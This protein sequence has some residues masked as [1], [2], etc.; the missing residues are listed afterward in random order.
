MAA[1]QFHSVFRDVPPARDG[2]Y[3]LGQ[4]FPFSREH[5]LRHLPDAA[6][7]PRALDLCPVVGRW[8]VIDRRTAFA[9]AQRAEDDL[10]AVHALVAAYVW[11]AG[12][13]A[14]T[15]ARLR[16]IFDANPSGIGESLLTALRAA[17]TEGAVA[18][19]TLL[20][21]KGEHALSGL[22]AS[23]FTKVLYFGAFGHSAG[24]HQPLILDRDVT[25]AVNALR[26]S[27]WSPGG[28]WSPEQYEDYLGYVAG[29]AE[30]W[31]PGTSPDVVE[32]TLSAAGQ[33]LGMV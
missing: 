21:R 1:L 31:R 33:A 20:S 24:L 30:E 28:P 32:R 25:V 12:L 27:D 22:D 15:A 13:K 16:F 26:G 18:A 29:W 5:W 4:Q 3:L 9:V 8:P 19:F 6:F 10:S 17:R 23:T 2:A 11:G 14:R 7:W